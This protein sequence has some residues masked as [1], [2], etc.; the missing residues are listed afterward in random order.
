[1]QQCS[2][3]DH[4]FTEKYQVYSFTKVSAKLSAKVSTKVNAFG[5]VTKTRGSST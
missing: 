1:M 5:D 4:S 3:F 2:T